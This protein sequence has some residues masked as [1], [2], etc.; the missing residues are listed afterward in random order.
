MI[1]AATLCSP[2]LEGRRR[3]PSREAAWEDEGVRWFRINP[4]NRSPSALPPGE[5]F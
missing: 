3:G 5:V 1:A 4:K 2:S